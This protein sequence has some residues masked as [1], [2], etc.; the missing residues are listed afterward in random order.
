[1]VLFKAVVEMSDNVCSPQILCRKRKYLERNE[2]ICE[3]SIETSHTFPL[4][5]IL[6]LNYI[7]NH[8]METS[9]R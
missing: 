9:T 2:A 1:M 5:K 4:G 6:V 7:E 8:S 3:S